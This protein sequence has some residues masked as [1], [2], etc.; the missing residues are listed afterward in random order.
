MNKNTKSIFNHRTWHKRDYLPHYFEPDLTQ[1]LTIR[2]YDSLPK[3]VTLELQ[4]NAKEND[5][6]Q[7]RKYEK[8]LDAGYGSCFFAKREIAQLIKES[9]Y[10]YDKR[11]Y[12]L[13]AWVVMP[14]HLHVMLTPIN[15]FS[16]TVIMFGLKSYT[17]KAANKLMN[18]EGAFWYPDYF[19][20]YIRDQDH[21]LKAMNYIA[22][23]P[24][25]A[26]LCENP[27]DWEF[28]S[29]YKHLAGETPNAT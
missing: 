7:I 20:R 12:L 22:M 15:G 27:E 5:K 16:L 1:M 24:V 18:R 29:F 6:V 2:I 13:D 3:N 23:N 25:K 10:Y 4:G 19:D 14:N 26:G 21:Y 9:L 8:L 11:R 28:S 17:A